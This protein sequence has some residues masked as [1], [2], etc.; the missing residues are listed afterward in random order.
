MPG[1]CR[2]STPSCSAASASASS[3]G[4]V[5]RAVVDDQDRDASGARR[6]STRRARSRRPRCSRPRCRSAGSA[7]RSPAH[8]SARTPSRRP[9]PTRPTPT[10][11]DAFDELGD[12]YELDGAVVHRVLAYRTAAKAVREAPR[13][14][15]GADARGHAS[16]AAGHRQDARRRS[17]SRCSTRPA[18]IPSADEAAREVPAGADRDDAPARA[19]GP[20][21]RACSTTSS[22]I[23]S[24][25][26][27]A[28]PPRRSAAQRAR[29]SARSSRRA[30]SRRSPSRRRPRSAGAAHRCCRAR[31]R[32][33]EALV[34][35]AARAPGRGAACELAG[36]RAPAGRQRQGPRHRR[37]R[38]RPAALAASARRARAIES[39]GSPGEAG[40]RGAHALGHD[41]RP[42]G[43]RRPTSSAT[44]CSTSPAPRRHNVALREAAVRRGLHVSE[45]GILDDAT[46][47]TLRCATRG[48]G[49]RAR[50][51]CAYIEPELREDR[52][53]L[54]AARATGAAARADRAGATSAATCTATRS[55][56]TGATRSRRWRAAAR[57]RGYEY[58]AITDHSAT[59]GFGNDV[60]PEQLRRQIEQ[61]HEANARDRRHR[62]ARRQRGRTSCPTARSTTTTSCSRELDWVIASVHTSFAMAEQ[63][64]TERMIAAIEHPLVDAIGHP[65]GPH[66]RARARPTRST[67]TRVFEARRAHGHDARDQRQP[68]PPRPVRRPRPRRRARRACG[69]SIDSDAH[70]TRTL[71]NMRWGVATARRAWLT[72]ADVANTRPWAEFAALRSTAAA[73]QPRRSSSSRDRASTAARR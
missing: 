19:S 47:E 52:G 38:Q 61:V 41:G 26:R 27:C 10:I 49:L 42:A 31:S 71:A 46:G 35:R 57:E 2:T 44:C 25:E 62:A 22:A 13:L 1:R 14:G 23:D 11:A 64:M 40:A 15:R 16:R 50:S 55:P 66:D 58:L 63:A 29:A 54:E 73:E 32:S 48:G 18:T 51:G 70:R 33:A 30:C 21:A 7:R 36:S 5:G 65:T 68:R 39:V 72:A 4:A 12:L 45:Y 28:R 43:R 34:A 17:S 60:S 9:W 53:E 69:S 6:A 37:H 8:R 56:P 3:P 59:H 67:S 20:S 24:L